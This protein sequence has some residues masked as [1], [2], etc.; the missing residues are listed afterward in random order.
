M[1]CHVVCMAVETCQKN[2]KEQCQPQALRAEGNCAQNEHV[3][4]GFGK[5]CV[6]FAQTQFE[7][8]HVNAAQIW[9]EWHV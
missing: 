8:N 4:F 1:S 6:G 2:F 9:F 3:A 7:H 5:W